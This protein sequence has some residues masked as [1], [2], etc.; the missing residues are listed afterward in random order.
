MG[1]YSGFSKEKTKSP[2]PSRFGLEGGDMEKGQQQQESR[3]DR[4]QGGCNSDTS[5]NY[6]KALL[7]VCL[8]KKAL[9]YCCSVRASG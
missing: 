4:E 1:S 3:E 9:A 6:I 5:S 7:S 8:S 2:D